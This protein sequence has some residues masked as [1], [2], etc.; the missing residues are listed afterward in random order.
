MKLFLKLYAVVIVALMFPLAALAAPARPNILFIMTDDQ[1]PWAWGGGGHPDA[2]TPNMDR[3]RA[4]GAL[5]ANYMV[6]TPVCSPARA[7]MLT[8]R[9]GTELGITDYLPESGGAVKGLDPSLPAWPRALHDAGYR[10]AH[11]GKWH[12]GAREESLPKAFGYEYFA[13][14]RHGAMVSKDPEV[15]FEDGTRV[16]PGFTSDIIADIALDYIAKKDSRPFL[17]SLHFWA[18]HANANK[19]A[20]G[21][22]TWMPLSDADWDLFKD[23]KPTLPEADYPDLDVA[24][25]ECMTR[26]YLASVHSVD[27]NL[28]R[29]L[30]ALDAQGLRDNTLIIFTSDHGYNLTHHGIWHKGNGWWL[31]KSSRATRTNLWDTSVRAPAILRWPAGI[32]AGTT[33]THT[34]SNLDW[35]P[36]ILS[37]AG[38]PVPEGALLRGQNF[39]PLLRG[40]SPPWNDNFFVQYDQ[41][42]NDDGAGNLRGYRTTEWKLVRDYRN[43]GKDELYHLATDPM[44]HENLIDSTDPAVQAQLHALD[45]SLRGAMETLNDPALTAPGGGDPNKRSNAIK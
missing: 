37:L 34:T 23:L 12:V 15:E 30:E 45:E 25:A 43:K 39:A 5:L 3:L 28:G 11:I 13:G 2:R 9:Y 20:D 29:I 36:S 17:I 1:G 32:A 19:N 26:E 44:E 7:S 4:E 16:V 41:R 33:V 14:W 24:R 18:P 22:R 8:S 38:V 6:T 35:F 40:E 21:D 42:E 10:T 27:R 31:L